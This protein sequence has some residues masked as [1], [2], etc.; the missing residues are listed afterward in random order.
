M[1]LD[2]SVYYKNVLANGKLELKIG[3]RGRYV[4]EQTGEGP[5]DESGFFVPYTLLNSFGPSGTADFFLIGK[6]GNAY[7][8]L[9]WENLSGNQYLLTPFYPM[10]DRNIRFGVSWEFWN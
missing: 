8:H 7:L 2:G 1:Y 6:L 4:S 3:F 9:I 5:L 10:Y